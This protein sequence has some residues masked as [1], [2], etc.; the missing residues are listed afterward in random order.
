MGEGSAKI[1]PGVVQNLHP[2]NTNLNIT[3]ITATTKREKDVVAKETC[4]RA[5]LSEYARRQATHRQKKE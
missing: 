5:C 4:L 1:A 3:N 2:N